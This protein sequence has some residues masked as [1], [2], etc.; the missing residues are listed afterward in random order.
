MTGD[1]WNNLRVHQGIGIYHERSIWY[2]EFARSSDLIRRPLRLA[3]K[4]RN[5]NIR[6]VLR[7]HVE[8][9]D[10]DF[11]ALL[12]FARFIPYEGHPNYI[13]AVVL[14]TPGNK[15]RRHQGLTPLDPEDKE[16]L[17]DRGWQGPNKWS[18]FWTRN[19]DLPKRPAL[20]PIAREFIEV[21]EFVSVLDHGGRHLLETWNVQELRDRLPAEMPAI[22]FGRSTI[23]LHECLE[24]M[25]GASPG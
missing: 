25:F 11:P 15:V 2:D 10:A 20:V 5:P 19:Y 6:V 1:G 12:M 24:V 14:T 7:E 8:D 22:G 16:K 3:I 23:D 18:I 21:A 17:R 9:D 4:W 13:G